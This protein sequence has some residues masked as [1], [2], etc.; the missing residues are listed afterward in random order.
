MEEKSLAGGHN[1]IDALGQFRL[2]PVLGTFG[3]DLHVSQ[4]VLYMLASSVLILLFLYLGMRRRAIVPGRFQAAAELAYEFIYR[5]A[6]DQIGHQGRRFFPFIFTLFFFILFGNY[7][8]LIPGSFTYTSHIAVTAGLAIMVFVVA[9]VV[10]L[11]SQGVKFF[12]HFLPEGA[13]IAMA[14]LLVPIEILTFLSRPVSL[15]IR[16]FAN[17]VAGHVMFEMFA[18]FTILLGGLHLIGPVLGV[19]PLIV[20]MALMALELLVGALQ[21][22]VFAILTCIYLR[23]AVAH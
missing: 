3:D 12:T 20:N 14:P 1:T 4:S 9:L 7:I 16:L 11:V 21:A 13:P 5:M 19:A 2:H 23:E 17:M 8:G 10:A 18:A 22:Y 6:S 15:S